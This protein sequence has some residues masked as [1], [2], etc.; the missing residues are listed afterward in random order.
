MMHRGTRVG[1]MGR[2]PIVLILGGAL[3]VT[4]AGAADKVPAAKPLW[5]VEAKN[6]LTHLDVDA[7]GKV[8]FSRDGKK[9]TGLNA[10]DGS[11]KYQRSVDGF[12]EKGFWGRFEGSTFVYSTNKELVGVDVLTGQDRW[13]ASPGDGFK[14]EAR[15]T[16]RGNPHAYLMA[17]ENGVAVWDIAKG[18]VLWSAKEPLNGDLTPSAWLR[19]DDPEAGVLLFL[20]RRT[21]LIGTDGK[22]LW[23]AADTGNKRRG[24]QDVAMSSVNGYGRLLLVHCSKQVVLLNNATGEVL[25]SEN[26]PTPEA[27]ADVDAFELH[28]QG[29][30]EP[31]LLS[32]GGRLIVADAKEGKVLSKTPE[33]SI[34]GQVAHSRA[35][36]GDELV[37]MT[38]VRGP[39]KTPNVG[40]HLYRVNP[41]TGEVKWHAYNGGT[42]DTRQV[43]SNVVGEKVNGPYYL[44]QAKGVLLAT[45]GRGVRLYD[46]D[47]GKERWAVD[48]NLPNSYKIMSYWG[49]NSFAIIRSMTQNRMYMSTNPRPVEG[50][51]VI[52]VAGKDEVHALDA[53]TGKER[54][55]SKSK[56]VSLI[57][58]LAASGDAVIFKE[59][60]HRDANDF[61]AGTTI[62]TEFGA[63]TYVEEPEVFIDESPCGFV[64]LDAASGKETWKCTDFE[65]RDYAMMGPMPKDASVCEV[66]KVQREK[67]CK[68]SKLGIGGILSTVR[69]G[70][71]TVLLGKSGVAGVQAGSCA[72]AWS[73]D[74]S[75]KK[76]ARIYDL[77]TH[78]ESSGIYQTA[79]GR[80]LIAHYG[81]DV[82]VVDVAAG[83]VLFAAEK[84]EVVKV[85]PST[86]LLITV[87]GNKLATYQLP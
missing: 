1:A 62:V 78:D 73:V 9:F 28:A 83:R 34:L 38:A 82:S 5:S 36:S 47:G 49:N 70:D 71:A 37:V 13:H 61:G 69:S 55:T 26:F 84:A 18:K 81:K 67:G 20:D 6:D 22:E 79:K 11:V 8:L 40:M 53:A 23:S 2:L 21:V 45:D 56:G 17:W 7:G 57:S 15:V 85:L 39:D 66:V 80:L 60:L 86:K 75:V 68:P 44:D 35:G 42:V 29:N 51:G 25:A 41:A 12:E 76:L 46:W 48:L 4:T 52:Y 43:L 77:D 32:L 87:D 14:L 3:A 31:L 16:S 33:N 10:S 27:A 59:G 24:G 50:P 72:A 64:G 63:P 65:A 54:W 58:G 74:G 30:T 19:T